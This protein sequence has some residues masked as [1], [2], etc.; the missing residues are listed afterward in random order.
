MS[1]FAYWCR[2]LS[3]ALIGALLCAQ[4]A[5]AMQTCHELATMAP[6][7]VSQHADEG[8][9]GTAAIA[10]SLCSQRCTDIHMTPGPA[11]LNVPAATVASAL[12]FPQAPSTL[13]PA[14][15]HRRSADAIPRLSKSLLFCSWLS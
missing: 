12:P 4:A 5:F 10:T 13:D 1:R 9:H 8:C 15:I 7:W 3:R 6:A 2:L 14:A 11:G